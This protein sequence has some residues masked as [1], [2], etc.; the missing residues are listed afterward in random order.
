MEM[1]DKVLSHP[2]TPVVG[3][4]LTIVGLAASSYMFVDGTRQMITNIKGYKYAP[5]EDRPLV[6]KKILLGALKA[7]PFVVLAGCNMACSIWQT[8]RLKAVTAAVNAIAAATTPA[9]I[10]V[11]EKIV[12]KATEVVDKKEPELSDVDLNSSEEFLFQDSLTGQTFKSTIAEVN[13]NLSLF[14][15]HFAEEGDATLGDLL[16]Y[17]GLESST[18]ADKKKLYWSDNSSRVR[19]DLCPEVYRASV[20]IRINYSY[21][22][23]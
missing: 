19:I 4:G 3:T 15:T 12:D 16:D 22:A 7:L 6:R 21:Y 23:R 17:F 10:P 18:L 14:N 2:A 1:L 11:V 5:A 20:I 8:K 9:A 13:N